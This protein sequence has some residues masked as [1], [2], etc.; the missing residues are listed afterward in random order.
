MYIWLIFLHSFIEFAFSDLAMV[1]QCFST[2]ESLDFGK[3]TKAEFL[4][5][6]AFKTIS[7]I[8]YILLG[9]KFAW[10]IR[11]VRYYE[12]LHLYTRFIFCSKDWSAIKSI[13]ITHSRN[14]GSVFATKMHIPNNSTD[15]RFNDCYWASV[16]FNTKKRIGEAL[17][18]CLLPSYVGTLA[19]L[20]FMLT[21]L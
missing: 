8:F 16:S 19:I 4:G 1:F 14:T 9:Y 21:L 5:I 20:F 3:T 10:Q 7:Y 12:T 17:S 2:F 13:P 11:N 6:K 15:Y 18:V